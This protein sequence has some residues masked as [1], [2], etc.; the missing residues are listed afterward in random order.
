MSEATQATT[1]MEKIKA[2]IW[3]IHEGVT[4][5]AEKP[6]P[7]AESI[8]KGTLPKFKYIKNV[9]QRYV[10]QK[11][12]EEVLDETRKSSEFVAS[13]VT[14]EQFHADK[15]AEDV[16][17]FGLDPEKAEPLPK[18]EEMIA[19]FK[20]TAERDP[21]LVLAS[22]YTIEGSNNGGIFIAKAVKDA[23]GFE[24]HEGTYHLQPYGKGIREKWGAFSAAFNALDI[25]DELMS[26]MVLVGRKTFH[27]MNDVA[28]EAHANADTSLDA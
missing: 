24:G 19:F 6:D 3:D 12:F 7:D 23:F 5:N 25:D 11:A 16:K 13:V 28:N 18:T 21:R 22:H 26:E 15:A 2:G 17:F 14:D 10:L 20:E 27:F 1:N 8:M 4:S 9:E